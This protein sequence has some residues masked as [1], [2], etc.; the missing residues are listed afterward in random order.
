VHGRG[1][2]I[3]VLGET[4]ALDVEHP[5]A[6]DVE[7]LPRGRQELDARGALDYLG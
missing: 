7:P 1:A 3:P 5:L 2:A 6:L 4:E